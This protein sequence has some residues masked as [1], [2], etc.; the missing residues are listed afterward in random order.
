MKVEFDEPQIQLS[1]LGRHGGPF[2]RQGLSRLVRE[3]LHD[4][5]AS[6]HITSLLGK[7]L[8]QDTSRNSGICSQTIFDDYLVPSS[9]D[10]TRGF[11]K[12]LPNK[13]G[14]LDWLPVPFSFRSVPSPGLKDESDWWL[15]DK[16]ETKNENRC[17]DQR[18]INDKRTL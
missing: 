17:F 13:F 14:W 7:V 1:H 2:F 12:S 5:Q 15:K 11:C 6:L 18:G 4:Q 16:K 3:G 9:R 10:T 8:S